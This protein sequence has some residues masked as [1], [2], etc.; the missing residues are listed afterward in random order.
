VDGLTA[1]VLVWAWLN[2]GRRWHLRASDGDLALCG[3]GKRGWEMTGDFD[4]AEIFTLAC[5]PCL[6][7]SRTEAAS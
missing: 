2:Y 6:R 4:P 5:L 3:V 1:P 7:I